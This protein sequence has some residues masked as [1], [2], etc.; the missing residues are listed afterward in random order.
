MLYKVEGD[1]LLSKA[2]AIVHGVGINDSMNKGLALE[3]GNKYPLLQKDFNR[4]CHQHDTKP[5]EAWMWVGQNNVRIVHLITH[6]RMESTDYHYDKA[7]LINVKHALCT[8]VKIIAF[9]KLTSIALPR[10]GTGFGDL[11]WDDVWPLIENILGGLDI[12][13]YVYVVYHAGQPADEPG[14]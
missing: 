10:I 1:I 3:L 12:P 11:E 5:G 4:W 14:I 6:E 7:T 2:Q 9:E 8:L 13:V